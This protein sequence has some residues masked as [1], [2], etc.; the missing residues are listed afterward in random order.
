MVPWWRISNN[1]TL[2]S[3]DSGEPWVKKKKNQMDMMPKR[4]I[5]YSLDIV[6]SN[7]Y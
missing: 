4:I 7:K 6:L 2:K 5:H 1:P 3:L